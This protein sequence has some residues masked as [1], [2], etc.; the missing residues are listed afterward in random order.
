LAAA[1]KLR[2][3][4]LGLGIAATFVLGMNDDLT[5]TPSLKGAFK[6]RLR[7]VVAD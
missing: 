6:E 1:E 4:S 2:P 5:V 3:H 7:A